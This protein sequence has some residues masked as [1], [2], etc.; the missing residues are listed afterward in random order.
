M[1]AWV[2]F[3]ESRSSRSKK[4]RRYCERMFVLPSTSI[5][6]WSMRKKDA[7]LD[8]CVWW[9]KQGHREDT[10]HNPPKV[11]ALMSFCSEH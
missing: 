5:G 3:I 4:G 1:K 6:H 11:T 10:T 2:H 9:A 8:P 7:L